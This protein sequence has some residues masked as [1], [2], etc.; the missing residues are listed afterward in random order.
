MSEP[1]V[2]DLTD[3]TDSWSPTVPPDWLENSVLSEPMAQLGV[4]ENRVNFLARIDTPESGGIFIYHVGIPY[5]RK[6]FPYPKMMYALNTTKKILLGYL[7]FFGLKEF[8]LPLLSLVFLSWKKKVVLIEGFLSEF[9]RLAQWQLEPHFLKDRYWMESVKELRK[10]IELFLVNLGINQTLAYRAAKIIGCFIEW[11]DSYRYRLLDIM[12]SAILHNLL[13]NPRREIKRLG[14]IYTLRERA[15]R[16]LPERILASK[17]MMLFFNLLSFLLFHPRIK[18]SFIKSIKEIQISKMQMDKSDIYQTL[19]INDY[20]YQGKSLAERM[21]AYKAIH[22]E[23]PPFV[24]I[25]NQ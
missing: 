16:P 9:T 12:S 23:D 18:R 6:G 8:R 3:F 10:W 20:N 21:W 25:T 19:P 4:H 24:T 14:Q 1:I 5:P 13:N 22:P 17:K 15:H 2:K 7:S 11:D